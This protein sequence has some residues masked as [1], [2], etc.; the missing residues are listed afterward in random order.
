V[1]EHVPD[2]RARSIEQENSP[3]PTDESLTGAI[4]G[5]GTTPV[6]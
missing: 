6:A 4:E 5:P 1:L 3:R 2:T